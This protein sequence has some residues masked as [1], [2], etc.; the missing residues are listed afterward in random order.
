[1]SPLNRCVEKSNLYLSS[2]S[3]GVANDV[4]FVIIKFVV[5]SGIYKNM[6]DCGWLVYL[7]SLIVV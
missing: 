6:H 3:S 2:S 7:A 4:V 5:V 1:M